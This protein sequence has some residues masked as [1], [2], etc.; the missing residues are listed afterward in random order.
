MWVAILITTADVF[1]FLLLETTGIRVLEM[2]FAAFIAVMGG[3]F[4][5]MVFLNHKLTNQSIQTLEFM[6]LLALKKVHSSST[7]SDRDP[8]RPS[9]TLVRELYWHGS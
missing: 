5:Y 6:K 9:Y 4:L 2:M 7:R 3:A 1:L 8:Q